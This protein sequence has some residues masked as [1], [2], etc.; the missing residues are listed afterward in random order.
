[1]K[2]A[3]R[4]MTA[5]L[6]VAA[7]AASAVAQGPMPPPHAGQF[8]SLERSQNWG[9][10]SSPDCSGGVGSVYNYYVAPFQT[11]PSLS[12]SSA[13]FVI[14][15]PK[16]TDDLFGTQVTLNP[17]FANFIEDFW[18]MTDDATPNH[19]EALEFD[20]VQVTGG[21][22][23]NWSSECNYATHTWDT[24]N[25]VTQRWVHSNAQCQPFTPNTWHHI[26][27]NLERVGAQTH[28]LSITVDGN[29]QNIADAYGY[30]PAPATNWTN[31]AIIWQ[32]QQDLNANG[33]SFKEW[34][35]HAILYAW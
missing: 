28:Y 35:D 25:E 16:Y 20:V 15:G 14:D 27:W 34:V 18:V 22:K 5:I 21:R 12:G 3:L 19:A 6:I 2:T 11:S 23:Y 4:F 31:G 1:M 32:V 7:A 30:Q 26:K 17:S 24:W 33:G 8:P 29:T 10:C 9:K 13:M